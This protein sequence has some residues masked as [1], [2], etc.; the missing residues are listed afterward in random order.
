MTG[1]SFLD[2]RFQTD[3]SNEGP[4][5][6]CTV[7]CSEEAPKGPMCQCGIA[8]RPNRIVG[9]VETGAHEYPWQ[10]GIVSNSGGTPFCGGS[11]LTRETVLTAAHCTQGLSA[12]NIKVV[13]GDHDTQV[14]EK[15]EK[16][17]DVKTII[18]HP[19]FNDMLEHDFA[20]LHLK[21]P[22]KIWMNEITPVCL[23]Q[24][25]DGTAYEGVTS[26]VTGWGTLSSGGEQARKLMEVDV[27]TI[28]NTECDDAYKSDGGVDSSMLCAK[29]SGK[30]A[31]QGDSGGPLVTL[32]SSDK[33]GTFY[34]QI[35]VVSWGIGCADPKYPGVYSRVTEDLKWIEENRVGNICPPPGKTKYERIQKPA[36]PTAPTT[37][38]STTKAPAPPPPP[39]G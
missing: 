29:A 21:E 31:C 25:S 38:A 2:M 18:E 19:G 12:S 20:I 6:S 30:D 32:E 35:G 4:G 27:K 10:V 3:G 39:F 23:P 34:S 7:S 36:K 13:L 33:G 16:V 15:Y 14:K 22:A 17:V 26:T 28:T 9:G 5:F 37:T 24:K 1:T 11:L 8:N